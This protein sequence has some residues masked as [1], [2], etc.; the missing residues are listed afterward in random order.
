MPAN[1]LFETS[2]NETA[3]DN[4]SDIEFISTIYSTTVVT[5]NLTA[6]GQNQKASE[7]FEKDILQGDRSRVCQ[8]R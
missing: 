5:R 1:D 8:S 7:Y 3:A 4:S 6:K 2:V